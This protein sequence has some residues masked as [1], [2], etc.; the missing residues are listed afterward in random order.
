[1]YDELRN[2]AIDTIMAPIKLRKLRD[3]VLVFCSARELSHELKLLSRNFG[4]LAAQYGFP[5]CSGGG[6][7]IMDIVSDGHLSVDRGKNGT[8][9]ATMDLM[10]EIPSRY[11]THSYQ[12][13]S[14]YTRKL[15]QLRKA[16]SIVCLPGGVGTLDE[17]FEALTLMQT[18]KLSKKPIIF[19]G[20]E[21]WNYVKRHINHLVSEKALSRS[22]VDAVHV[23]NSAEDAIRICINERKMQEFVKNG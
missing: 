17:V 11:L 2:I 7:G 23:V 5:L 12:F 15:F 14:F 16:Q 10:G 8:F 20:E 18:N 6:C 9:G 22:D 13:R 21:Y 19:I 1:M 3:S 4:Q